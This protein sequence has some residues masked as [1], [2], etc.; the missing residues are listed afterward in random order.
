MSY[1]Y[2]LLAFISY[3]VLVNVYELYKIFLNKYKQLYQ[4]IIIYEDNYEYD[5]EPLYIGLILLPVYI[6]DIIMTYYISNTLY[7]I[8][9]LYLQMKN[10]NT[11]LIKTYKSIFGIFI[12]CNTIINSFYEYNHIF[13]TLI[14]I[15]SIYLMINKYQS[16][17]YN[18]FTS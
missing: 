3:F 18:S 11:I 15:I 12:S 2:S 9:N 17:I 8:Y 5:F 6:Q 10:T 16:E 14:N 7:E 13:V 4:Y 1:I